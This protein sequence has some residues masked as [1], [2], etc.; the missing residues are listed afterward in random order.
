MPNVFKP[1][2]L[3]V[4]EG[5]VRK[6]RLNENEPKL[7]VIAP[8]MPRHLTHYAKAFWK[9]IV[10][11]LLTMGVL[12]EADSSA[13]EAMCETVSEIRTARETLKRRSN[14]LPPGSSLTSYEIP[15]RDGTMFREYPEARQIADADRR[16]KSWLNEFGLTPAARHRV[17]ASLKPQDNPFADF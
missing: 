9:Q 12:T 4:I 14:E 17:S 13:L 10:P 8:P 15:S 6:D 16:L 1:I 7:P 5:T 2:P 11:V 3:K